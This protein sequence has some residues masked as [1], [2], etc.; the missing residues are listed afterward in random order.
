MLLV[1]LSLP[2]GTKYLSLGG[3]AGTR[4]WEP[5]IIGL[6]T[7]QRRLKR[8]Y[9]GLLDLSWGSIAFAP[10]VFAADWP[11]PTS[12]PI[13]LKWGK[14][15]TT[16]V[17]LVVGTAHLTKVTR[18]EIEYEIY[19]PNYDADTLDSAPDFTDENGN[20]ET[21]RVYPRAFGR[22]THR[23]PLRVG[24]TTTY[25]YHKG[26]LA[27]TLGGDWFVYDDGVDVTANATDNGDGT[28]SLSAAPVGEVTV[29][30]TGELATLVDIFSWAA[31]KLGLALDTTYARNP[32][33]EVGF[34]LANQM[35]LVD[36]LDELSSF[37]SH[38][39]Y[40]SDGTLYLVDM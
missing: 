40:I 36:L 7:V 17:S 9:G 14:D 24:D 5:A 26:Y 3:Y 37:F 34:W 8:N 32:S 35:K 2:S 31:G 13:T 15:D 18:D 21:D 20:T 38:F 30:G 6:D 11:P 33:P 29:S 19:P 12:I 27:G 22:V 23:R 25:T 10:D 28:F 16:A 39:F 4:W 1:E